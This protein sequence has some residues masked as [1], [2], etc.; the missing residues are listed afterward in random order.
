MGKG[1]EQLGGGGGNAGRK[2]GCL[3]GRVQDLD[4][5]AKQKNYQMCFSLGK[6]HAK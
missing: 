4:V 1:W 5:R 2:K 3:G 6:L